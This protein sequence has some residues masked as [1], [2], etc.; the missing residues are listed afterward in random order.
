MNSKKGKTITKSAVGLCKKGVN[1]FYH[2]KVQFLQICKYRIR[3]HGF[4]KVFQRFSEG[5][6]EV[7]RRFSRG[8]PKENLQKLRLKQ[9]KPDTRFAFFVK[10]FLSVLENNYLPSGDHGFISLREI[11]QLLR[12]VQSWFFFIVCLILY[13]QKRIFTIKQIYYKKIKED[14]FLLKI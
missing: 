4:P 2:N 8:F 9:K 7:F 5:F 1:R 12:Y 14:Y 13:S 10:L 3:I 11:Q 6:P